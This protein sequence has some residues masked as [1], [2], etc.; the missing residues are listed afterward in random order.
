MRRAEV[1]DPAQRKP[2]SVKRT[3]DSYAGARCG[4]TTMAA[5][6]FNYLSDGLRLATGHFGRLM[7]R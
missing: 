3:D 5:R 2:P 1:A 4:S 7:C 6:D